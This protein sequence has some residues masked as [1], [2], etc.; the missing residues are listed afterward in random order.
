MKEGVMED[1]KQSLSQS[2][3]D[4]V[5]MDRIMEQRKE[6]EKLK[7][8]LQVGGSLLSVVAVSYAK[9]LLLLFSSSANNEAVVVH[10]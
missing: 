10:Q 1:S 7:S 5:G 4:T 6:I 9:Q 3:K 8:E 2:V